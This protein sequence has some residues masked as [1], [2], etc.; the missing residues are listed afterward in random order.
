M[1][2]EVSDQSNKPLTIASATLSANDVIITLSKDPGA[3]KVHVGF[4][5]DEGP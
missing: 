5:M 1:S 2:F 3:G 4:A